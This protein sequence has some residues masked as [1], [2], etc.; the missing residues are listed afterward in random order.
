MIF[1]SPHTK[2]P[3]PIVIRFCRKRIQR[4]KY[5]K[6]LGVLLDENL[7]WKYHINELSKKLSRTIGIFYKIRH[8]VPYEVLKLLYYSLL[9]SFLS[10][11]IAVWGF[12][13]K[14]YFQK[15][16]VLQKK[17][18]KVMTSNKQ[19]AHSTPIFA[20]I[21]LL[22]IDDIRQ[23]QLLTF[24][25]DCLN[26]L[27]PTYFHHYFVKC[28]QVHSYSTRLASRGDLFL[29]RK[30][31]FQYGIRSIEYNGERLWNMIPSHIREASSPS[32]FKNNLNKYF[33]T[34]YDST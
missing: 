4:E 33:L 30:N 1:H 17:I 27:A 32:V 7:S 18:I 12:T 24:V 29:E 13:Y 34:Q 6:F 20:N 3:E 21:Q 11:G 15:L 26:K 22:K 10:Y 8:F 23:L 28:S 14:S 19:T 2:L 5:V 31:T 25:Y 9:H 16:F